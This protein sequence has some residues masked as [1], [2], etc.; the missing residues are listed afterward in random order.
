MNNTYT[1]THRS[2]LTTYVRLLSAM[3]IMLSSVL[4]TS[5]DDMV[6]KT[7]PTTQLP[8][9]QEATRL[10]ILSEGLIHLNNSS[11]AMYDL[12]TG[13]TAV[14]WFAAVNQRR[15][16]DTANDLGSYGSKLYLV[17]S[18]SGLV[19]VLDRHTGRSMQQILI[20]DEQGRSRQPRNI[21]FYNGF[22]YVSSF[23]GTVSEIDTTT[24][25]TTRL[26]RVGRNP[27]G[28]AL[29]NGKLYVS[30]SGGLSF[31]NYDN[32]L[33]VID[34]LSFREIKTIEVAA[35]PFT[36]QADSEG[37]LYVVS[38]GNYGNQHYQLHR[39]NTQTDELVQTFEGV[40]PLNFTIHNDTAWM[41]SFNHSNG[42]SSFQSFDCRTEELISDHFI[43]DGTQLQTPFG[44]AV[45]PTTGDIFLTDARTYTVKGDVLCFTRDG[46]LKY[47]LQAVGLNPKKVWVE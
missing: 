34:P 28:I 45:H 22:A 11:L 3:L 25:T 20:H 47:R 6:D 17:V 44:I 36:L 8:D 33:S 18:M 27:D 2:D 9:Q 31:P 38:R 23:D 43:T 7:P 5:C 19:E 40:H 15:L 1:I 26:T 13:T 41:Y 4:L 37:D 12:T 30:N 35:N 29:A 21:T 46:K 42:K 14:D 24:L 39:I 32:T 16:G 10:Y